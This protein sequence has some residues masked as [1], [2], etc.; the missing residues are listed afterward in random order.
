[1]RLLGVL[2]CGRPV[3]ISGPVSGGG[4]SSEDSKGP[5]S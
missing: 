3:R 5:F 2:L 1:M 4:V